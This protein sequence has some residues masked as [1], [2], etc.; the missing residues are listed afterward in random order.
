MTP[1][2]AANLSNYEYPQ[3]EIER[4]MEALPQVG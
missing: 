1:I 2:W 4:A 3:A